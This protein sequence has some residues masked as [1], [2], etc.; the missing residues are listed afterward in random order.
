MQRIMNYYTLQK[1]DIVLYFT[2]MLTN[3]RHFHS[4][5]KLGKYG[6]EI[7]EGMTY[8]R[9]TDAEY[10]SIINTESMGDRLDV[11]GRTLVAG[12]FVYI[13]YHTGCCS[14]SGDY[15]L[16][17]G[18]D[19]FTLNGIKHHKHLYKIES[20][21]DGEEEIYNILCSSY[22]NYQND[23][24]AKNYHIGDILLGKQININYIYL[25]V[26]EFLLEDTIEKNTICHKEGHL[27]IKVDKRMVCVKDLYKYLLSGKG[28]TKRQIEY[29]N[30]KSEL[31]ALLRIIAMPGIQKNNLLKSFVFSKNKKS[32]LKINTIATDGLDKSLVFNSEYMLGK[33]LNNDFKYTIL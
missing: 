11:Y 9:V 26:R 7:K 14:F 3:N 31:D 2:Y 23:L 29:Y 10:N 13:F 32:L 17:L 12:D 8:F 21:C 30:I 25:G 33:V 1:G 4:N 5:L 24:L 16:I 19:I 27:Y 15:G 22:L 6:D 18:D 20:Y 28:L